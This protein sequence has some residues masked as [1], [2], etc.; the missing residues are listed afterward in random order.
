MRLR[1]TL[2]T[3]LH[4]HGAPRRA[5]LQAPA[6]DCRTLLNLRVRLP[7]SIAERPFGGSL[8]AWSR[9]KIRFRAAPAA[10][11]LGPSPP[12]PARCAGTGERTLPGGR[13]RPCPPRTGAGLR[14]QPVERTRS[15]GNLAVLHLRPRSLRRLRRLQNEVDRAFTAP[16]R[17]VG[18]LPGHQHV[19]GAGKRRARPPSRPASPPA[20]S[21]S[22]SRGTW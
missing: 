9:C 22:P 21:T 5:A 11:R 19:A 14:S 10:L 7:F 13:P 17:A 15:D 2:G 1:A 18:R 20:T 8:S 16:A 4:R 12:H 3:A 6:H